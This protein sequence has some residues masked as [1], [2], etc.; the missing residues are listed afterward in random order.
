M[1]FF[2]MPPINEN[3]PHNNQRKSQYYELNHIYAHS[4]GETTLILNCHVSSA[5]YIL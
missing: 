3:K 2:I 5:I 1:I 4:Y